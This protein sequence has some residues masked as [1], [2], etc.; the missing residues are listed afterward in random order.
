MENVGQTDNLQFH[1]HGSKGVI[2]THAASSSSPL[3]SGH[4]SSTDAIG[5]RYFTMLAVE[6]SQAMQTRCV[7]VSR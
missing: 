5:G 2:G 7:P 3:L 1:C 4:R 6:P